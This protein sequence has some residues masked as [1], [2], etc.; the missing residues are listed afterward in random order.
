MRVA[1]EFSKNAKAYQNY[2]I[3]QQKVAK[4]LLSKAK[5]AK[6][7]IDIGAGSG[8]IFSNINWEIEKFIAIDFSKQM[9]LLHPNSSKVEKKILDFNTKEFLAFLE[10]SEY[11]LAIS[12]SA[13]QWAKDLQAIFS[14]IAKQK[15]DFAFAIFT[16]NTFKTIHQVAKTTSPIKSK[17]EI[18]E[19]AK[20]LNAKIEIKNY[21]LE[22]KST[23]AIFE[24]IK[25][26]GVSG[27]RNLLSYKQTKALMQNYPHNFLEF[28]IIFLWSK[29]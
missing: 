19:A 21:T 15:R 1:Q 17:E 26:S 23:K 4:E 6:K 29:Q 5:K 11:E 12:S 20:V 22:F 28:E 18:L 7:I 3:I 27:G 25:K 24:Y 10:Q 8:L 9:L 13:L 2:N 14:I 16:S